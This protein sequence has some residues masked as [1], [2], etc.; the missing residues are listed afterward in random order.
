MAK[1]KLFYVKRKLQNV[2]DGF[3]VKQD[4]KS[5]HSTSKDIQNMDFLNFKFQMVEFLMDFN[6]YFFYCYGVV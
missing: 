1:G 5:N 3:F 6:G 2:F 4:L